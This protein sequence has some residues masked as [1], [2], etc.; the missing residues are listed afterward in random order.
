MEGASATRQ[1]SP[2]IPR[3]KPPPPTSEQDAVSAYQMM[4]NLKDAMRCYRESI[5]LDPHSRSGDQQSCTILQFAPLLQPGREDL[6]K[7][8]RSIPNRP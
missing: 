8:S 4:F 6:R 2:P 3:Q 7:A 1:P 5:K